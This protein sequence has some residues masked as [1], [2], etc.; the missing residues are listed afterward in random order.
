[1]RGDLNDQLQR[2]QAGVTEDKA[3]KYI[4]IAAAVLLVSFLVAVIAG[5]VFFIKALSV[6]HAG[7]SAA[8]LG[9]LLL[10]L[11]PAALQA[12]QGLLPGGWQADFVQLPRP[13]PRNPA[14][15]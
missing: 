1:M 8:N 5:T 10:Q 14:A 4:V 2:A 12:P 13:H 15:L 7:Q 9:H 6:L 3:P 11:P